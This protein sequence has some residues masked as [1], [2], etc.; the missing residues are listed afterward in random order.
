MSLSF[1]SDD[2]LRGA[3]GV[4]A[5]QPG[6]LGEGKADV[7]L[8][9]SLASLAL[10]SAVTECLEDSLRKMGLNLRRKDIWHAQVKPQLRRPLIDEVRSLLD[11]DNDKCAERSVGGVCRGVEGERQRDGPRRASLQRAR[12]ESKTQPASLLRPGEVGKAFAF[13]IDRGSFCSPAER[14]VGMR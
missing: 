13:T 5:V 10:L 14:S 3:V 11:V 6:R 7:I 4:V 8:V 12:L 2:D 1:A 9:D